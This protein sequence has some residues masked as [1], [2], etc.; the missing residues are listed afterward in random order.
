MTA[1]PAIIMKRTGNMFSFLLRIVPRIVNLR[2]DIQLSVVLGTF[3]P[4]QHCKMSPSLQSALQTRGGRTVQNNEKGIW[5]ACMAKTQ[6]ACILLFF[7]L[8]QFA[9]WI[10]CIKDKFSKPEL[11]GLSQVPFCHF[12]TFFLQN[13]LVQILSSYKLR[14]DRWIECTLRSSKLAT[15][16]FEFILM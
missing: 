9:Y 14:L 5:C 2:I 7:Y 15:Y 16:C 10:A 4:V 11:T 13:T 3:G 6:V 8:K 1:L 12:G